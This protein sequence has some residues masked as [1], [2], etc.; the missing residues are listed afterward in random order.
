[1]TIK[2]IWKNLDEYYNDPS[3]EEVR[4]NEFDPNIAAAIADVR[5]TQAVDEQLEQAAVAD[6]AGEGHRPLELASVGAVDDP[7]QSSDEAELRKNLPAFS[8]R[9][10]LQ[11]TGAATVFGLVG[12]WHKPPESLAPY[13]QHPEGHVLGK[14][15]YFSTAIRTG[16]K[17]RP[18]IAKT[19][20][21]RPIKLEGN[22]DADWTR[23]KLDLAG[24]A[25]LLDLYD[26]DR[27]YSKNGV[28]IEGPLRADGGGVFSATTWNS[29]DLAVAESIKAG[30]TVGLI[31]PA[32]DGV[33]THRL[34][35]QLKSA[36]GD[37]LRHVAY[38][39]FALDRT[40]EARALAFGDE[41]ALDPVYHFEKAQVIVSLGSD[42]LGGSDM[43]IRELVAYGDQ[44]RLTNAGHDAQMG[45]FI[46]FEGAMSQ[47]GSCSDLRVR[48]AQQ[49]MAS[50]TWA[51]AVEVAKALGK[52]SELPAW[53]AEEA[54]RGKSAIE[55]H[56]TLMDNAE[57]NKDVDDHQAGSGI[58]YAAAQLIEAHKD[59]K[60]SLV[61][62]G[63]AVNQGPEALPLLVAA[64]FLNY[65]LGNEGVTI[66]TSS[67]SKT[68]IGANLADVESLLTDAEAGKVKTLI[69]VDSN[70]VH[71]LGDSAVSAIKKVAA[72]GLVVACNDRVDETA[73]LANWVAPI[74]HELE[75]W[76]DA[77]PYA[78]QYLLQQ[79]TIVPLWDV[80]QWQESLM[81]FCVASGVGSEAF[82]VELPETPSKAFSAA[83]RTPL[84]IAENFGVRS[85]Q[86]MVLEVWGTE[87]RSLI[88]SA[89]RP[90]SFV[91]AAQ[92]RGFVASA[93]NPETGSLSLNVANVA[94]QRPAAAQGAYTLLLTPSRTLR[95]GRNANNAWLQETPD[96]VSKVTWDTWLAISVSDAKDLMVRD[97]SVVSLSVNGQTVK[98]PV[99]VQP[100]Q[101]KGQ[102]ELI[103]GFGRT[104]A[105][106]VAA[107]GGVGLG[108]C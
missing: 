26:P 4:R 62:A 77:E 58:R 30:G 103:C 45:A 78:G 99:M 25:A 39:P 3:V 27:V 5:E 82:K 98:A 48:V 47:G 36:L 60:N 34:F 64:N 83:Q 96:P 51:I 89:A 16:G 6:E 32:L 9:G 2:R 21:F 11:L 57:W 33:A 88:G 12:C 43:S 66:E 85:W 54:E 1:M 76:G 91:Q 106:A 61:Y 81:S 93:T 79:P 95:D 72:D 10:F 56:P 19:Y 94:A 7:S 44:R 97:D 28:N 37:R 65:L 18:I 15:N 53:A 102:L 105:G 46:A 13:K 80:R 101:Q 63:G 67:V 84:W 73:E 74:T 38:D 59:G 107:E 69:I 70:P 52:E 31:T 40:R 49:E 71:A 42:L 75:S 20:D 41:A 29:L 86:S 92:V 35:A 100:G 68:A 50:V 108:C 22:Y 104:K 87:V 55:A 24:Q 14:P 8:R 17:A 23:G 90:E